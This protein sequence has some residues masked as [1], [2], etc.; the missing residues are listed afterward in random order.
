MPENIQPLCS[1][2]ATHRSPDPQTPSAWRCKACKRVLAYL[3]DKHEVMRIKYKDFYVYIKLAKGGEV[4]TV[5]R[6][7]S[8]IN[9]ATT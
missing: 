3:D 8:E 1:A 6:A 7:C 2:T 9:I 4:T 5:C